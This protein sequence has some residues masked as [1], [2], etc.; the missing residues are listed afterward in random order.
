MITGPLAH[1]RKTSDPDRERAITATIR[2][3]IA[4]ADLDR[5]GHPH[6]GPPEWVFIKVHT[7]GALEKTAAS[8]L[9]D[10]RA[11]AA[12]GAARRRRNGTSLHYV[13]AREMF[14]VA[15]RRDG[16]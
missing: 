10:G 2:R 12:R 15:R 16:R 11:H 14:N 7:H 3:A 6:R 4:R 9:G 5:S 13:T 1:A 8:L